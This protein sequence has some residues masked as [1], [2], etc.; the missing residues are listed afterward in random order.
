MDKTNNYK[1]KKKDAI[2]RAPAT[3]HR[4]ETYE[5]IGCLPSTTAIDVK[6][7]YENGNTTKTSKLVAFEKVKGRRK[8][9][10]AQL[11]K[12]TNNFEIVPN[13]VCDSDLVKYLAKGEKMDLFLFDICGN[14]EPKLGGWFC[15]SQKH[16]ANGMRFPM[17]IQID[18]KRQHQSFDSIVEATNGCYHKKTLKILKEMKTS[19]YYDEGIIPSDTMLESMLSQ[20]FLAIQSMPRKKLDIRQINIYRNSDKDKHAKYMMVLDAYLFDAKLDIRKENMLKKIFNVYNKT[21]G[22]GSKAY[23]VK[24]KRQKPGRK[25]KAKKPTNKVSF[26]DLFGI[27]SEKDLNKDKTIN[28]MLD[29]SEKH[30]VDFNHMLGGIRRSLTIRARAA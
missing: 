28:A 9:V 26:V 25:A 17:T 2:G 15:R 8:K 4:G 27:K 5:V 14:Y 1:S 6:Q 7:T 29:Y 12:H 19:F 24:P 16:F 10:A 20:I 11:K 22:K 13:D 18:N 30:C 3:E 21:V 23:I